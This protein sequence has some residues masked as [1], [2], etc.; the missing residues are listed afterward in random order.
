VCSSHTACSDQIRHGK[1]GVGWSVYPAGQPRPH[2]KGQGLSIP[3]FLE[4][5]LC[6]YLLTRSDQ[7][8]HSSTCG[9]D[10]FKYTQ[11]AAL[12]FLSTMFMDSILWIVCPQH[13][14][15]TGT[16]LDPEPTQMEDKQQCQSQTGVGLETANS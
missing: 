8:S 2:P 13:L 12:A 9:R 14:A 11:K 16:S 10:A 5:H 15:R 7:I 1:T 3:Q 4:L 6:P